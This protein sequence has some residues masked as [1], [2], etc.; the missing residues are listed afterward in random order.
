MLVLLGTGISISQNRTSAT[1]RSIYQCRLAII[2][3]PMSYFHVLPAPCKFVPGPSSLPLPPTLLHRI[4]LANVPVCLLTCHN[5][6]SFQPTIFIKVALY[7]IWC[8]ANRLGDSGVNRLGQ[9]AMLQ[10]LL[11]RRVSYC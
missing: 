3:Y 6:L 5:H 9:S 8:G 10:L 2:V 4:P 11:S 1:S 7:R